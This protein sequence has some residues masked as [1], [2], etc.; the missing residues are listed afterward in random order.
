M[1]AFRV[2]IIVGG[3]S[4]AGALALTARS[5]RPA[6]SLPVYGHV[7]A[8]ALVDE[9]GAPFSADALR[10]HVSVVDFVFTRCTSSCPRLTARMADLQ[11]RLAQRGSDVRLVSFSVDPENDTPQVLMQYAAGVH[12]DLA[13]WSFVTGEAEAMQKAVVFG[14]KMSDAKIMK[15]ANDYDVVHGDWFVL[16]DRKGDLRGYYPTGAPEEFAKLVEDV[17]RL[18]R[19]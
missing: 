8:L 9:R 2:A 17:Q 14:F 4:L 15:G 19:E 3:F 6:P 11:A 1:N 10:G 18:E 7:P 13:R 5:M 12:A 16:V